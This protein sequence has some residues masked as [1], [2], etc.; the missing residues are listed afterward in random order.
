MVVSLIT[1]RDSKNAVAQAGGDKHSILIEGLRK[2]GRSG[3][4]GM[5]KVYECLAQ[6]HDPRIVALAGACWALGSFALFFLLQRSREC[7]RR[8]WSHWILLSAFAAGLSV[9]A[10]HFVAILAYRGALPMSFDPLLTSLSTLLC[11]G[12]FAAALGLL[13]RASSLPR[14]MAAG[15]VASFGVAAMH[16]IGMSAIIVPAEVSYGWALVTTGLS[17]SCISFGLAFLAFNR[18]SGWKQLCLPALG[19]QIAVLTLHFAAMSATRFVPDSRISTSPN[20]GEVEWL[21]G[22]ILIATGL[23]VLLTAAGATLDRMLTDLRG[24]A[25]ATLEGLAIVKDDRILET[26]VRF[27]E[28]VG[29]S[30]EDLLNSSVDRWLLDTDGEP[31]AIAVDSIIEARPIKGD[32]EQIF[33]VTSHTIEYRGRDCQVLAMRDLT[34]K[35]R[36]L[37]EIEFLARHDALTELPNR[38]LFEDRL[39]RTLGFGS[40]GKDCAL[41]ALDLDRFKTVNDVFGHAVGDAVLQKVASILQGLVRPRD[42][43]ARIGGDEFLILQT[44]GSQPQAAEAL[45]RRIL[46]VFAR[47][48]NVALDPTAVGVSIGISVAP[49]DAKTPEELRHNADIALYRAKASG[50]GNAC[51]FDADMDAEVQKRRSLEHDLRQALARNELTLVYQPLVALK[52]NTLIGYE[53]LLRW[54]HPERG[55]VPPV[56]FIP[57]AEEIGLILQI[58]EWVLRR[59]CVDA[60]AWPEPLILAVNVSPVQFNIT[61][62]ATVVKSALLETGFPAR[63]LELEITESVL[64]RNKD[65]TVRMLHEIKA[66][67]VSIAMDDFGT[68]YSSLSN[69]RSFPFDKI[70]IDRSF[71]SALENDDAARS[72]IRAIVGLG[73]SLGLPVVAEG[74]ETEAQRIMVCE[75]GCPQAQGYLFGQPG[76]VVSIPASKM[77]TARHD[78]VMNS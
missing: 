62:L 14:S 37:R 75:E 24:F 17:V 56:T 3:G 21:I 44:E 16:F 58:G 42:I 1:I 35:K 41:L 68:G 10:T 45:A 55:D 38:I 13:G 78:R 60:L 7:V 30:S 48:M 57:I 18:M 49:R 63:R 31:L 11:I 32:P 15:V 27:R 19:A 67:G 9:W 8:R 29:T 40:R 6:Q 52:D 2:T 53:A 47:K 26:N 74:V 50:R 69:L 65:A 12:F 73:R 39:A 20:H 76:P 34:D 70:K 23:V 36:A 77:L 25:D 59:A 66:L 51:F 28:M 22:G 46:E 33:E 71:V 5:F 4:G 72:I 61:N 54:S 43:V 64:L